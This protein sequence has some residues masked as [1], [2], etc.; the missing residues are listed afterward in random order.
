MLHKLEYSVAYYKFL[1]LSMHQIRI[2]AASRG[3]PILGDHQYGAKQAFGP[4]SESFRDRWI[5]LHA[6]SLRFRHPMT[7]ETMMVA[8]E[9]LA[10]WAPLRLPPELI[11]R[12]L[13]A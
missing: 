12:Q 9:P 10:P 8:K 7:R 1:L 5:A 6:V 4:H 11:R 13:I 2:Q 3:Y